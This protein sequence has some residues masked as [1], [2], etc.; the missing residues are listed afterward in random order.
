ML[1][2][3]K[4]WHK[5]GVHEFKHI[6]IF[7]NTDWNKGHDITLEG[8]QNAVEHKEKTILTTFLHFTEPELHTIQS[9]DIPVSI[10][11]YPIH[12]DDTIDT[13]KRKIIEKTN[14]KIAFP[15]IYLF[16]IQK[17]KLNPDVI[18]THLTQDGELIL[19]RARLLQY[20]QNFVSFNIDSFHSLEDQE[21]TK[22]DILPFTEK[23]EDLKYTLGQKFVIQKN[24][25]FTT[26]P[27]DKL[28]IDQILIDHAKEI[29][30]TENSKLLL[31][32]PAPIDFNI[33]MCTAKE[34]LQ[35][36][37]KK[38][39]SE[40]IVT[41]LYFPLL[42][43]KDITNLSTLKE[44]KQELL[45]TNKQLLDK[46]FQKYTTDINFFYSTFN[47]SQIPVFP[48][49]QGI[50]F[51]NFIIHPLSSIN[52]PLDII[53]KLI[54]ATHQIPFIKINRGKRRDNI[55]RLYAPTHSET[56]QK[57]PFLPKSEILK[58]K[59][60]IGIQKSVSM[61]IKTHTNN[62]IFIEFFDNGDL[63]VKFEV[64]TIQDNSE[65]ENIIR[66]NI[67]PILEEIQKYMA[68]S[69]YVYIKFNNLQETNIEIIDM[70]YQY[71]IAAGKK[72]LT[73]TLT[74]FKDCIV[75][76]FNIVAD[77]TSIE[78]QFKRVAYFNE[79]DSIDAFITTLIKKDTPAANI[80]QQLKINYQLDEEA[81][82]LKYLTWMDEKQVERGRF[83][84][85]KIKILN[86]PG[87]PC[88]FTFEDDSVTI[89]I[90]EIDNIYYLQT[91]PIY[92]NTLIRLSQYKKI[93]KGAPQKAFT[94]IIKSIC[95][96]KTGEVQ[97]VFSDIKAVA[98]KDINEQDGSLAFVAGEIVFEDSVDDDMLSMFGGDDDDDDAEYSDEEDEDDEDDQGAFAIPASPDAPAAAPPPAKSDSP[99]ANPDSESSEES[100]EEKNIDG[101]G[102][103]NPN[104]FQRK[105]ESKDPILYLKKKQGKFHQYSR[106]CPVNLRRQP[107][108]LT[109]TQF[110][111]V[112]K[113][114][115]N[116]IKRA[117]KYGSSDKKKHWYICPEYWCL[118]TN[119]PL[120][121]QDLEE[122]KREK[123]QLCG[124]SDDPYNNIIPFN[125]RSI[126]KGKYIYSFKNAPQIIKGQYKVTEYPGFFINKH[127]QQD[128]CIP[129]CFNV[130]KSAKQH[131]AR[132]KCGAEMWSPGGADPAAAAPKSF[133]KS[134]KESD[135]IKEGNKFPIDA[136]HWGFL[137]HNVYNFLNV[138]NT[139]NMCNVD[140]DICILRQGVQ[141]SETQSFI[142]TIAQIYGAEKIPTIQEMKQIIVDAITI[143]SFITYQNGTLVE[144]F[145]NDEID[146]LKGTIPPEYKDTELFGKFW[147]GGK[148]KAL[149]R[150]Y[151]R[152]IVGAFENFKHFMQDPDI[153]IDYEYLWDI[154]CTP[155]EKLFPHGINLIILNIPDD[156]M[157]QNI[158]II[159]PSNHYSNNLFSGKKL[160]ALILHR[161]NFYEPVFKRTKTSKKEINIEKKF[162]L[163]GSMGELF[164]WSLQ[165]IIRKIGNII[166][167]MCKPKPSIEN[168]TMQIDLGEGNR[169]KFPIRPNISASA[170]MNKLKKTKYKV[171]KQIVN[172]Y[173]KTIGF[174]V[175]DGE[176]YV[177]LPTRP[178]PIDMKLPYELSQASTSWWNNYET[179]KTML[180]N[181]NHVI[182]PKLPCKPIFKIV[183]D[184]KIIGI[185]TQSDQFVP[186]HP[187]TL[188]DTHGDKLKPYFLNADIL[189]ANKR[190]W[191]N[192]KEDPERIEMVQRIRLETNFYN[193][194]R[195]MVRILLNQYIGQQARS[196]IEAIIYNDEISYWHKL[197]S[198]IEH[199][200]TLMTPHLDF[201]DYGRMGRD[202]LSISKISLCLNMNKKTCA[203]DTACLSE[204][205]GNCKLLIPGK[206]LLSKNDNEDIYYGRMAD[207]LIRYG[208]IRSFVFEPKKFIAFQDIGYNLKDNEILLLESIILGDEENFFKNLI[209]IEKNKYVKHPQTFYSAQPIDTIPYSNTFIF[210]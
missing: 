101:I 6:Y 155:N 56:G 154:I 174:I 16:A 108:I 100:L 87:F 112:I 98:E 38:G 10:I 84:N 192:K 187:H 146:K 199:L 113:Q 142:A 203:A 118:K 42:A 176:N 9:Q 124:D 111:D 20:L 12:F 37:K 125:A 58:F 61:A 210:K 197:A 208:N 79:M 107:V 109:D 39:V 204:E 161:N 4:I 106:A 46:N 185:L 14:L 90:T 196:N 123:K 77:K 116:A 85:K 41:Q 163:Q 51:I 140:G 25:P 134:K 200:K 166:K 72:A 19:T 164:P 115:P 13:L 17:V 60:L 153:L 201:V 198:I 47:N 122:A 53:F 94:K 83:E 26:D 138:T 28:F 102:L 76:V 119:L 27:F 89:S 86:N 190:I 177:Y 170:I 191:E 132:E 167:K 74:S 73:K 80:I 75:S 65:I 143:D 105:L 114:Q 31:Q 68:Q 172:L 168:T 44:K 207:E 97:Q 148:S 96:K 99:R 180:Q 54:H 71:S 150:Q 18:Y 21:F 194:F 35:F 59:K 40:D 32:Y 209:P 49:T 30:S 70:V 151:L 81:A 206:N 7:L 173:T 5:I 34:V 95:N 157:T 179:T 91:I 57:I 141:Y 43:V 88:Y 178:S 104:Y 202:V 52:L 50:K 171:T 175:N 183:D 15:E 149:G 158:G 121:E 117:I 159:C 82:Q 128:L 145:K 69:G 130:A 22:A 181:L 63:R 3:L 182:K 45:E 11:D 48:I 136:G 139:D 135:I 120:S 62:Y 184:G 110:Q 2:F 8:L 55:Y 169:S 1:P 67:N 133:S 147:Q 186:T 131:A 129:C 205:G 36:T 165:P 23:I 195:N 64:T 160:T 33:Y 189:D 193:S 126:P 188:E 152:E 162:S 24:Y 103:T 78:L 156:D 66:Q 144:L 93:L 127:P 29:T 92:I 137:P